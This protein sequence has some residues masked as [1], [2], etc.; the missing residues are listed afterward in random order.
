MFGSQFSQSCRYLAASTFSACCPQ[1]EWYVTSCQKGCEVT[2]L[3]AVQI[4][5][6]VCSDSNTGW[7]GSL[8]YQSLCFGIFDKLFGSRA[9]YWIY[10]II[11]GLTN[12]TWIQTQ[13]EIRLRCRRRFRF[14][15]CS[16][17]EKDV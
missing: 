9:V 16:F 1:V 10:E 3:S 13:T 11:K 4:D 6:E 12:Q 15:M 14:E 5:R 7:Y 17:M 2:E 8:H